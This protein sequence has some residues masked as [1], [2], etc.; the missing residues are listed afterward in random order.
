MNNEHEH[1]QRAMTEYVSGSSITSV[2]SKIWQEV[3]IFAKK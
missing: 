1:L 2:Q 3:S